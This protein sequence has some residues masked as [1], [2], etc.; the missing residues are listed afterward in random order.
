[1]LEIK[2]I[3]KLAELARI[4][5]PEEEKETLRKEVD[6]ILGYIGEISSL[7]APGTGKNKRGC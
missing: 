2:D 4:E 5:I 3:E 1:M 6:S 7:T